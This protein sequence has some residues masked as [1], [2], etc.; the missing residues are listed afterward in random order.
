MYSGLRMTGF[1]RS[2]NL[3]RAGAGV[4]EGA[5]AGEDEDEE[6]DVEEEVEEE[7]ERV[8]EVTELIDVADEAGWR[9]GCGKRLEEEEEEDEEEEEVEEEEEDEAGVSHESFTSVTQV[10]LE[11]LIPSVAEESLV[12]LWTSSSAVVVADGGDEEVDE[13]ADDVAT[14]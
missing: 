5:G 6:E 3:R 4:D 10:A 8:G 9:R 11:L 2:K 12:V 13:D 7:V 14:G 1:T